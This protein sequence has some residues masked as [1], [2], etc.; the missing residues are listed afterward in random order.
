MGQVGRGESPLSIPCIPSEVGFDPPLLLR[1]WPAD[2]TMLGST[3]SWLSVMV[4]GVEAGGTWRLGN[5]QTRGGGKRTW[6]G[7]KTYKPGLPLYTASVLGTLT[8]AGL[9][10][11]V[12]PEQLFVSVQDAA[13][14]A[15]E[16]LVR[17][18][19]QQEGN[20]GGAG[21]YGRSHVSPWLRIYAEGSGKRPEKQTRG[22]RVGD[23]MMSQ[24]KAKPGRLG[25]A[26]CEE[27]RS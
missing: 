4:R 20:P 22:G 17:G 25:P 18:Q 23:E 21:L 11:R 19:E 16:R 26:L 6:Y 1:S 2:A 24:F 10:N 9:L 7:F 27:L 3:F 8:Q 12:T 13:A 14:H 5:D 15:L